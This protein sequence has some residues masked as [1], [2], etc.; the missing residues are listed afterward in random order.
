MSSEQTLPSEE[1]EQSKEAKLYEKLH[2]IYLDKD[3]IG[4]GERRLRA[5]NL[6][7]LEWQNELAEEQH[8][9]RSEPTADR[10][11]SDGSFVK[12]DKSAGLPS[13]LASKRKKNSD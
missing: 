8:K 7:I 5:Y 3:E 12:Q 2:R 9:Y 10:L 1:K 11:N 13:T 4:E 6:L